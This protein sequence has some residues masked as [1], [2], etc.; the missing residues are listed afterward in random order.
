MREYEGLIETSNMDNSNDFKS[1][2]E[3]LWFSNERYAQELLKNGNVPPGS[4]KHQ[5]LGH[6][7][8]KE[9]L[10]PNTKR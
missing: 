5:N 7:S 2:G 6:N 4:I 1:K 8:K 3:D 9:G 10:G